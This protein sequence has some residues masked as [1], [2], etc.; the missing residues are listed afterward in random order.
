MFINLNTLLIKTL[1]M[2]LVA[3]AAGRQ[4]EFKE[5]VGSWD[6]IRDARAAWHA[7]QPAMPHAVIKV[8]Y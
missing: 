7:A 1:Q 6:A 8:C 5:A 4:D 3:Q 2:F